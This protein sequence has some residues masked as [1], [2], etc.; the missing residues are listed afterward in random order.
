MA[1]ED[2]G[3]GAAAEGYM[4]SM[5]KVDTKKE[6]LL[7]MDDRVLHT[8][9]FVANEQNQTL[10][11]IKTI[12][13]DL[14]DKLEAAGTGKL[15]PAKETTLLRQVAAAVEAVSDK[16]NATSQTNTDIAEGGS[17]RLV[18]N[19]NVSGKAPVGGADGVGGL[20]GMIQALAPMGMMAMPLVQGPPDLLGGKDAHHEDRIGN[21]SPLPGGPNA[22]PLPGVVHPPGVPA[23]QH[24]SGAAP[25]SGQPAPISSAINSSASRPESGLPTTPWS[26]IARPASHIRRPADTTSSTEGP[27]VPPDVSADDE[28]AAV[29]EAI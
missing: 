2:L 9:V 21:P 23:M 8:S 26:R 4:K 15:K 7:R 20:A 14:D 12:I 19:G 1:H 5:A 28:Y 16:V 10:R 17:A 25:I 13:A 3:I 6:S 18:V 22:A 24:I 27:L 11:S 29:A